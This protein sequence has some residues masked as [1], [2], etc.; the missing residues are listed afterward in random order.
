MYADK[1]LYDCKGAA[2]RSDAD[3]LLLSR[4]S[5]SSVQEQS[6]RLM[7]NRDNRKGS[8]RKNKGE[9]KVWLDDSRRLWAWKK[10]TKPWG[11]PDWFVLC[12]VE[13]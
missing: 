7:K 13:K 6:L 5:R 10:G 12:D 4:E 3:G 1:T 8:L 11:S 9:E 2:L